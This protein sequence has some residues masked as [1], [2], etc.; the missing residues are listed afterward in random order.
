[1]EIYL[2]AFWMETK[3]FDLNVAGDDVTTMSMECITLSTY[4][5]HSDCDETRLLPKGSNFFVL[6]LDGIAHYKA[7]Q[8]K[9][10]F[11]CHLPSPI[12][13]VIG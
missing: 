3:F 12:P 2:F 13:I 7:R 9:A 1:V 11:T 10:D 4:H 8:D 5:I 6:K